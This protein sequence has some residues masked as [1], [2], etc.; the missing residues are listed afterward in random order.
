M[1]GEN[2]GQFVCLFFAITEKIRIFRLGMTVWGECLPLFD[3]YN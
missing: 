2:E 3:L 1:V